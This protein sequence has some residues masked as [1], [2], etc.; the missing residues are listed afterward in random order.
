ML[1]SQPSSICSGLGWQ[2]RR[3]AGKASRS[4]CSIQSLSHSTRGKVSESFQLKVRMI[5]GCASE[6]LKRLGGVT[7][8]A[9]IEACAGEADHQGRQRM[10][11]VGLL[12]QS[13]PLCDSNQINEALEKHRVSIAC[14]YTEGSR[15]AD[16]ASPHQRGHLQASRLGQLGRFMSSI[17]AMQS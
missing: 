17:A 14:A 12:S 7:L 5:T 11:G 9:T 4:F 10:P 6:G 16:L 3:E 13:M 2:Q 8:G 15:A 1:Q